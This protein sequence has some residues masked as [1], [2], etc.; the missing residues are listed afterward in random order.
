M[1][2]DTLCQA[3]GSIFDKEAISLLQE[4]GDTSKPGQQRPHYTYKQLVFSAGQGCHFCN[5]ILNSI[6]VNEMRMQAEDQDT[7]QAYQATIREDSVQLITTV[8][9]LPSGPI[10]LLVEG[11]HMHEETIFGGTIALSSI[12]RLIYPMKLLS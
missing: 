3:C 4:L 9:K 11:Y 1:S 7:L 12:V 8:Q 10:G 2:F 5:V 6:S